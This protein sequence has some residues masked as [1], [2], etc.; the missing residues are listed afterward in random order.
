MGND[1][2][3]RAREE[4]EKAARGTKGDK[5]E[6][7]AR[8]KWGTKSPSIFR[9]DTPST[10]SFQTF[11]E[12]GGSPA[13][14][15]AKVKPKAHLRPVDERERVKTGAPPCTHPSIVAMLPPLAMS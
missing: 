6:V 7:S 14:C 12:R 15:I 9:Y 4:K 2:I 10:L 1:E 11:A 5:G 3:K 13:T 8:S